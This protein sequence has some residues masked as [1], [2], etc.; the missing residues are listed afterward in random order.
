M[1]DSMISICT[2]INSLICGESNLVLSHFLQREE[3][4]GAIGCFLIR[5]SYLSFCCPY[6]PSQ[7]KCFVLQLLSHISYEQ[8]RLCFLCVHT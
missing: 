5:D 1:S 2:G 4:V 3:H 6:Q 8:T 7:K